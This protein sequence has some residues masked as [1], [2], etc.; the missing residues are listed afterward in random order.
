MEEEKVPKVEVPARYRGTT[1]GLSLIEVEA[2]SVRSCI[3]AVEIQHPGF[4]ELIL[5]SEGNVRRFVRL[6]VNG[7]ALDRDAV[8]APVADTDH[9][10]IL[11]AA[12]G[13]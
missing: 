11:A 8:D 3:E 9:V 6:F 2:D 10:Q 13:G 7:D 4:R 5:D 12:A 1:G